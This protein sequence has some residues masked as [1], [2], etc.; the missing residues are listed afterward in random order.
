VLTMASQRAFTAVPEHAPIILLDAVVEG[1]ATVA[2]WDTGAESNFISATYVEQHGLQRL[3]RPSQQKVKYA[4]NTVRP[5][6]GEMTLPFRLLTRGAPYDCQLKLIVA[7][8]QPRFDIVLGTPFC[9]AHQPRPDWSSMTIQLK[10]QG[11]GR[12]RWDS[13]KRT[14]ARPDGQDSPSP[15]LTSITLAAMEELWQRRALDFETVCC[16][17]IHSPRKLN[18]VSPAVP[19]E[20]ERVEAARCAALREKLFREFAAVF[21][22]K[23]PDV[24]SSPPPSGIVHKIQLKEGAQPYSRPLRRMSTQELD[25]LKKQLQGYLDDGRLRPSESPWGTNV[26]FAKKKDGSLRFCV[27]YRGLNELTVRNSYPL[28]HMDELFDR[29]QGA[30]YYSKIDLR[31][32]FYQIPLDEAD[33]GKTAFRT[34]YGHFEWTV[35]PMGLTNAPATFQHLMNNTFRSFLDRCVLV[36][37]DDIVVYSRTIEE[38]ERDVRAVLQQLKDAGLYAKQS[39]CELF[40][41]EIEFLGHHVGRDGLR[42]M[43]DKVQA[44]QDWPTP[45]NAGE[46]R[47]FLG[48]AGYYR[49]FV[50]GFS[51]LASPLH[52]LTHTV[53]GQLFRWTHL[54]QDA[55]ELL[56]RKLKEAPVLALPDPDRPYVVN[57]DASDFATGAVLQQDFGRGLQPVAFLSHKMSPAE[58]RYPTHDK[59]MLAI[60]HA[61]TE[62]RTYLQGR[63]AFTVRIRTDHNS[64]QYFMTQ[65]SLSARQARWLDK[66][67]DFDFKIEYVRGPTNTVADALSRRADLEQTSAPEHTLATTTLEAF[68]SYGVA[69]IS[70]TELLELPMFAHP[71]AAT[72]LASATRASARL[73]AGRPP[74]S[75]EEQRLAAIRE[76]TTSHAPAADRPAPD[77]NGT[78][79]MPSQ[80]CAAF[81]QKGA[82]CGRRTKKGHH[83][84]AHMRLLQ[85]LAI[86]KSTV[87]G[88]GMGLFVARGKNA[89]GFK[90]GERVCLYTG[91]WIQLFP[92]Q[93]SGGTYFVELNRN[94]AL[95]GA[96][97]N[98][99]LGRWANAPLGGERPDGRPL[100]ANAE[101]VPHHISKQAAIKALR[102][103]DP[104]EEI[105]VNYGAA[106]W[107]YVGR[108][109]SDA[110]EALAAMFAELPELQWE[111]K[112]PSC[113]GMGPAVDSGGATNP[114][115]GTPV[116]RSLRN[117][118]VAASA[119]SARADAPL[120]KDRDRCA[121]LDCECCELARTALDRR[122]R[123]PIAKPA[124]TC[125][126]CPQCI[127]EDDSLRSPEPPKP[128]P[129]P[130]PP[131]DE[132]ED[133]EPQPRRRQTARRSK[134]QPMSDKTPTGVKLQWDPVGLD[135]VPAQA[136]ELLELIQLAAKD[137]PAYQAVVAAERDDS[138]ELRARNGLLYRGE[139]LVIPNN[140]EL[141]TLLLSEAHD[142]ASAGHTGVAATFDR[143][144]ERVHW[145]GMHSD[146]HD[147]VVS[148]DSCQRNKVEQRRP[149]GLLRP[150][151]VPDEPGYALN[152]DFVFGLPR[153]ERGHTGYLSLTCRLSN[154]LQVALCSD[155]VGAEGA[156]QLVFDR[157]VVHYGLP[158]VIISDRDPRFTG[159]FW[160]ALWSLLDTRLH[161]STAGHPQT[162]GKAENRQRTANTMLRH[163]VDFE[164]ADWDLQLIR[165][166]HAI[167]NTR[168]ASS[169]FTPFEIMFRR[170][171]R[172][173]LDIALHA[174]SAAAPEVPAATNLLQRH[175]YLWVE[176]R[177][178]MV[179]AQEEQKRYADRHRRE[180]LFAVGDE[181]LLSTRDL[182]L[183]ASRDR[184]FKLTARFVGPFKV[185]QVVNDNAY[186]LDLPPQLRVH[187]VQ[188]VSKL[189]RYRRS[190][191][192]FESR[193]QPIDRPPPECTDPAG[194]AVYEAERIVAQR[195]SRRRPE[196]LVKWKGYPN[197]DCS[198]EPRK[199]LNCPELLR[200][201]IARQGLGDDAE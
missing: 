54:H 150:P 139:Q 142:S 6:K 65:P 105:L 110:E 198:W 84:S 44:V 89:K 19:S 131:S 185:S 38:H 158:A 27:D 135:Y 127:A 85:R 175:S 80:R 119:S 106:Y 148:C 17:N 18:A 172:L 123:A 3:V 136:S 52:E 58:T 107:R 53:D 134:D 126:G 111:P 69:A 14:P 138:S 102:D 166:S 178:N 144:R 109:M 50:E 149:A 55:F 191:A 98:T 67:A 32:G 122:C 163:Y 146:V 165:A 41:H 118:G 29:L 143:L 8:L 63:Q 10:R 167:N 70:K 103:I 33:M 145:A 45:R 199:N 15:K 87:P 179:R 62:W 177:K 180:E 128:P 36:F 22:E 75:V 97:T 147:Y 154:M 71:T 59:E 20:D 92:D 26:I 9:K 77:K 68:D 64:L 116:R 187:P 181:V 99:A 171:P 129:K 57:T 43:E 4:D 78:I 82:Q 47:S 96:R 39:K 183:L 73:A 194:D 164:Q 137:D 169:G 124:R 132:D 1:A 81:N 108:H 93:E 2:L 176:A 11:P 100:T 48:L 152:M 168:S 66:L 42:M 86:G 140:A 184:A 196:Y 25:E 34:R 195:G 189:R 91:D 16:I 56:K 161:M 186:K 51:K 94:L 125:R 160:Q 83:C 121:V 13:C 101:L 188:N 79:H 156:A 31:T 151:P 28:P 46:V 60:I 21:P 157:W 153:T 113:C 90:K 7:D 155:E 30:A 197:E 88:A 170:A 112:A 182:S 61:L 141:R 74:T 104:G 5:A 190:P 23:L 49:R 35:L 12:E 173:P 174:P 162:D 76:A 200:E 40:M 193:P 159:K 133:E 115:G 130:R 201:F 37:L 120:P 72:L 192:R 24:T 114:K 95:D 117:A